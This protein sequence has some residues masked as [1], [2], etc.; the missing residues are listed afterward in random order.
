MDE[1]WKHDGIVDEE[2]GRV[3]ADQIPVALVGVDFD[4]EAARVSYGIGRATLAADGGETDGQR[5]LLAHLGE[6][7]RA[8]VLGDIVGDLQVPERAYVK[9]YMDRHGTG[10]KTE[11]RED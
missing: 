2:D 8:A 1:A 5:R 6:D 11:T 9:A 10:N 4:G 7:G 3:V